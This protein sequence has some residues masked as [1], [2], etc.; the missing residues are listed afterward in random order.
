[1]T[2]V[3]GAKKGADENT[4]SDLA[5]HSLLCLRI[6]FGRPAAAWQAAAPLRLW[7]Y[8]HEGRSQRKMQ[9]AGLQRSSHEIGPVI[10]RDVILVM[11]GLT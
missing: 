5:V 2:R 7:G 8:L 9:G 10:G 3:T 11:L 4:Y 1:M 6:G